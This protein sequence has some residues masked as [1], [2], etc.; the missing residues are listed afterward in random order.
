MVTIKRLS[1][2][3]YFSHIKNEN[4]I[5]NIDSYAICQ[6]KKPHCFAQFSFSR[7][8]V[9]SAKCGE[10]IIFTVMSCIINRTRHR[11]LFYPI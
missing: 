3:G 11:Y 10:I 4:I 2:Y 1:L 9:L 7:V 5:I 6:K 8:G